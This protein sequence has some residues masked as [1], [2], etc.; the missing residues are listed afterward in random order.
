MNDLIYYAF[1]FVGV[2]IALTVHEFSHAMTAYRLGDPTPR[3][4]GRLSLNPMRHLDPIGA[5]CML[6]IH[7]GWAKPVVFDPRYFKHPRRDS[8]L[9]WAA[10]PL[11]N[12][13]VA[14]LSAPL[15]LLAWKLT[16]L[17][18][19]METG[20]R[21]AYVFYYLAQFFY[22]FLSLNLSL[23]VFNLLPVYPLD[24][25]HLLFSLLP[26][27][28]LD[29]LKRNRRRIYILFLVWLLLGDRFA[30]ILLGNRVVAQSPVL[31]FLASLFSLSGWIAR[32]VS[33]L[34]D[35]ILRLWSLIPF[36]A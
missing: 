17:P 35:L 7:V 8:L 19:V 26:P 22:L 20:Y 12:L 23:A 29:F 14:F 33:A 1:L 2:L 5:L 24:G 4:T 25:S 34:T 28:A 6:L 21:F 10:G 13:S 16:F 9:T 18:A 3:Y 11:S 31:S 32:A 27:R 15:F 30:G 36:L